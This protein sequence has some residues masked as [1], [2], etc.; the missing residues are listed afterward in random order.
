MVSVPDTLLA[1]LDPARLGRTTADLATF[2]RS[3]AAVADGLARW[4]GRAV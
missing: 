3:L 1:L 4:R 2:L